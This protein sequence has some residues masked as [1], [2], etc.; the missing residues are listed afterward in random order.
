MLD[1]T[2]RLHFHALEKEMDGNPLQCSCLENPRDDG[3]WW[4]AVY[5]AT[6]S[7]TQLKRFSSSSSS[8]VLSYSVVSDSVTVWTIA[9]Q[10]PLSMGIL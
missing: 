4:P 7:Q 1:T 2:E 5:G 3:A 9:R 10:A 8:G 6:L